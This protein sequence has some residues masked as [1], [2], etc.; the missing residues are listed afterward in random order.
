[1]VIAD[2]THAQETIVNTVYEPDPSKWEADFR[3][4]KA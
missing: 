4:K 1:V 3:R 2:D